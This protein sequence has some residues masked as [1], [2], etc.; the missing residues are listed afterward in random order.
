MCL[1]I[2]RPGSAAS[3]ITAEDLT[4]SRWNGNN[5]GHG[6]MWAEKGKLHVWKSA[7]GKLFPEFLDL[8]E[9][10]QNKGYP[11]AAHLRLAT[12]GEVTDENAHPMEVLPGKL[13][14]V[15]NGI[16]SQ[17][18]YDAKLSDTQEFAAMLRQFPKGWW[19]NRMLR[20][21]LEDFL[22]T[23]KVVVLHASGE[24]ILLNGSHGH[25]RHG[26]WFSNDTYK[27]RK[28]TT[29]YHGSTWENYQR[30][31]LPS[32]AMGDAYESDMGLVF[33]R[34][35]KA[36]CKRSDSPVAIYWYTGQIFHVGC[37]DDARYELLGTIHASDHVNS[38]V[39]YEETVSDTV[40]C[41]FCGKPILYKGDANLPALGSEEDAER[42]LS[43]ERIQ[44]AILA[45][46]VSCGKEVSN[47]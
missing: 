8:M 26:V 40:C 45:S 42:E 36:D 24:G 34:T 13:G 23:N 2:F 47:V 30:N 16:I 6:V 19:R 18:G 20:Y 31:A 11:L 21:V 41:D 27:E 7:D 43:F 1:A 10:L 9:H 29:T 12:H 4:N 3:R 35:V 44:E 32:A 28:Y 17:L 15:H 5:D 14:I 39:L 37:E 46:G 25:W 38:G 22:V 33:P